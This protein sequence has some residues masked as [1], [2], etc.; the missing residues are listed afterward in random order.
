MSTLS[1]LKFGAPDGAE[2]AL[3]S[4]DAMQKQQLIVVEDAAIVTWQ[5]GKKKPKFEIISTNLTQEQDEKLRAE[6]GE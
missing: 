1:V 6:F 5:A 4:L 3:A 2:Q